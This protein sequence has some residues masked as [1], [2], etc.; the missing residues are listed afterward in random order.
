[1]TRRDDPAGWTAGQLRDVADRLRDLEE[2]LREAGS[3]PVRLLD[4]LLEI[5]DQL[6]RRR[7]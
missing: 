6:E 4:E 7:R 3:G 5:A 1:M 2:R